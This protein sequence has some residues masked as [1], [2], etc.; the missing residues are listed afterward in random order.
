MTCMLAEMLYYSADHARTAGVVKRALDAT[1]VAPSADRA[2]LL[3]L[4][5]SALGMSGDYAAGMSMMDDALRMADEISDAVTRAYV[6]CEQGG[7]LQNY[8]YHAR[9]V[10]GLLEARETFLRAGLRWGALW[11]AARLV[12]LYRFVGRVRE[13]VGITRPRFTRAVAAAA[14]RPPD[15]QSQH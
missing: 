6:L 4:G 1:S 14:H 12:H 13:T 5:G 10:S 11:A 2:R 3:A 8:G 15:Q 9:A 7:L